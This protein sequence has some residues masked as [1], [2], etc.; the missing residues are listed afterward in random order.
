MIGGIYLDM[1]DL[2]WLKT[3]L[4]FHVAAA[5]LSLFSFT[6]WLLLYVGRLLGRFDAHPIVSLSLSLC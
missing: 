5:A 2:A 6:F 1:L 3:V 4:W